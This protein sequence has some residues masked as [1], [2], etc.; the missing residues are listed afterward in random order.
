MSCSPNAYFTS[1]KLLIS[2]LT[3]TLIFVKLSGSW[4]NVI[5]GGVVSLF[6]EFADIKK[7]IISFLDWSLSAY[8][9]AYLST[10]VTLLILT[11]TDFAGVISI[12]FQFKLSAL[13]LLEYAT[14][15]FVI[16]PLL[17]VAVTFLTNSDSDI[18]N[19][20]S[21]S[22][23]IIICEIEVNPSSSST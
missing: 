21:S 9:Y 2:S 10:S 1:L 6:D 16:L 12:S 17:L 15:N 18:E 13:S 14:L 7:L 4:V 8:T 5:V 11:L 3:S 19:V 22:S 23:L 20:I